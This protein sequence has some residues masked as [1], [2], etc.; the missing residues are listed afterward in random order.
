MFLGMGRNIRTSMK[1]IKYHI[2][3]A[4]FQYHVLLSFFIRYGR[5]RLFF[6]LVCKPNILVL[7]MGL[8]PSLIASIV[9]DAIMQ[10][11]LMAQESLASE[12]LTANKTALLLSFSTTILIYVA[13]T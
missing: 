1:L 5:T 11:C 6:F 2:L 9:S 10:Y 13:C 12:Q 8:K 7:F 3:T 4:L